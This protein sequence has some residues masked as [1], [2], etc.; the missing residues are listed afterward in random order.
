M[1]RKGEPQLA[2]PGHLFRLVSK[3]TWRWHVAIH[4]PNVIVH[5]VIIAPGNIPPNQDNNG[6][7][8]GRQEDETAE[9]SQCDDSAQIQTGSVGLFLIVVHGQGNIHVGRLVSP[10]NERKIKREEK[11]N[12]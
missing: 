12:L 1:S 5:V 8:D 3:T 11:I 2:P 6:R 9:S 10:G 7:D 4:P